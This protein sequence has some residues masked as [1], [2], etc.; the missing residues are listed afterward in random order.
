MI[1]ATVDV[2]RCS[3]AA[4]PAGPDGVADLLSSDE[5]A[6]L[7]GYRD[8]VVGLRF[9]RG[10]SLLRRVLAAY[11]GVGAQTVAFRYAPNG[12]PGIDGPWEFNV[13][14]SGDL[15]L[16][17]VTRGIPVG[18]DVEADRHEAY[19]ERMARDC[20]SAAE[21][22]AYAD[23]PAADRTAAFTRAWTCKEAYVKA[24][25]NGLHRPLRDVEIALRPGLPPQVLRVGG[26]PC[27][28]GWWLRTWTPLPG[29]TAA[30]VAAG[31][32]PGMRFRSVGADVDGIAG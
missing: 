20:L 11:L 19:P 22:R 25:G 32:A 27:P 6:R 31:G 21:H 8:T 23:L 4:D 2:W 26:A 1:D 28:A 14:H 12:K 15:M 16:I 5:R 3:L 29:F 7:A 18:V 13:S 30:L 9:A 10:R 24:E 17:A